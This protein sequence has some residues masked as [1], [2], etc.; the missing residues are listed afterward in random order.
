MSGKKQSKSTCGSEAMGSCCKIEAILSVD[1]RGQMVLPK[2]LRTKAN[3]NTGDK[4]ALV[5][6]DKGG[7]ICCFS[8]FKVDALSS[9][10]KDM[11]EPLMQGSVEKQ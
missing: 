11:L 8:I 7:E 1:E 9:V 3:I 6:W 10:V 5:S 4:L 2:E